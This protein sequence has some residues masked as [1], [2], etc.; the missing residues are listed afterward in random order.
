MAKNI[1]LKSESGVSLL[2]ILIAL[3]IT[4][5]IATAGFQFYSNISH[6]GE[7]QYDVSEMQNLCRTSMYDIRKSLRSAGYMVSG[8]AFEINGDSLAVYYLNAGSVDTTLYFIQEYS[9]SAYATI[10]DLP[11]GMNLYYLMKQINSNPPAIY[12]DFVSDISFSQ[13][14]AS[15]VLVSITTQVPRVD[16]TYA[17]NGGF[18]KISMTERVNVRNVN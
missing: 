12:T 15:N 16:D 4:G 10:A 1:Q 5:I 11:A 13:I 9:D 18:R 3:L 6:Q 14:D 7:V 8:K 2:E 17:N